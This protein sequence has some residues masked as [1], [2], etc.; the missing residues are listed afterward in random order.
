MNI[1]ATYPNIPALNL[2]VPTESAQRDAAVRQVVPAAAQTF[3]SSN[4]NEVGSQREKEKSSETKYHGHEFGQ[5]ADVE[6]VTYSSIVHSRS[7]HHEKE[8]NGESSSESKNDGKGNIGSDS[9]KV[10]GEELTDEEEAK[11]RELKAR[12]KEV[13]VHE[14]QHK[15]AG[16]QYASQPSYTKET[17][18]DGREYIVDGKVDISISEE[19]TPEKTVAKMKQVY[20]AALAPAEPSAQDRKVAAEAKSKQHEAE[21]KISKEKSGSTTDEDSG[22]ESV[23]ETADSSELSSRMQRRNIAISHRYNSSWSPFKSS[24]QAYA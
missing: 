16:G 5:D 9:K 21:M 24:V 12:D 13:R 10:N 11:V 14:Q 8:G 7:G 2:N 15:A 17:G 6:D 18:P 23:S 4:E 20:A 3:T 19:S 1:V 22:K